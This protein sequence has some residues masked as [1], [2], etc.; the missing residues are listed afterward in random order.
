M[1]PG[2]TLKLAELQPRLLRYAPKDGHIYHETVDTMAEAQG[3]I[4]L[5]PKCFVTNGGEV[6]TH[7]VICWFVGR[8]VP[9]DAVPGPA[10]WGASGLS[11]ADLSLNPS[12]LLKG[13]CGW[14]GFITNG[15]VVTC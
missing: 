13:G 6:G 5:C 10:R 8:G 4:L 1:L 7:S 2:M 3:M 14:H 12:V 9:D 15:E 11:L